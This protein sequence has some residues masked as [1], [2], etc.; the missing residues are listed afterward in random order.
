MAAHGG[1][2]ARRRARCRIAPAAG[3]RTNGPTSTSADTSSGCRAA[4]STADPAAMELQTITAG[5]P[6]FCNQGDDIG[7]SFLVAVGGERGVA[8]P[9]T[10]QVSAGDPVAPRTQGGGE[11]TIGGPE[12]TH[13]GHEHH[14]RAIAGDVV[15]DASFRPAEVTGVAGRPS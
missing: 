1:A 5:P 11:E 8:V 15:T 10:A 14:Q 7:G 6:S 2:M 3:L 4:A 9:V 12:V 13:A